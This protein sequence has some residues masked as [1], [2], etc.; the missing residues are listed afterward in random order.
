[1]TAAGEFRIR[2]LGGVQVQVAGRRVDPL[3]TR[4]VDLL[5]LLASRAG[6]IQPR[7]QVA[8]RLWP[9]STQ[10]QAR[11]NLRRELHH[12][13]ALLGETAGL[14]SGPEGLGWGTAGEVEIDVVTLMRAQAAAL[15]AIRVDDPE[16]LRTAMEVVTCAEAEFLPGC[17][18]EWADEVR[19]RLR[20]ATVEVC[21]SATRYWLDRGRPDA[22]LSGARLRTRL[23]PLEEVGYHCLMLVHRDGGD[24]AGALSTYHR[25][26]GVLERE[27]GVQPGP[28]LQRLVD[29]LLD[30]Q[31]LT[32]LAQ[33][34]Q[35]APAAPTGRGTPRRDRTHPKDVSPRPEQAAFVGRSRELER[36]LAAWDGVA[37]S[38]QRLA[39]IVG[40]PGVGK[41]RLM[42][43]LGV[44]VRNRGGV[45]SKARCYAATAGLPLAPVSEWL[46]T[47]HLRHAV[48]RL[49]P[50]WRTEV[51]RLAP[52]TRATE[53][54]VP[55]PEAVSTPS[56][57]PS[58]SDAWQRIRFFESLARAVAAVGR[59]VLLCLDDVQWCD[60]ATL[61]WVAFL[62]GTQLPVPVLVV[63]TARRGAHTPAPYGDP[64]AR[65]QATA[66]TEVLNLDELDLEDMS[67]LAETVLGRPVTGEERALLRDATAGNPLSVIVA[68]RD[69]ASAS[70][71]I[72]A[73]GVHTA[74]RRR[75]EDLPQEELDLAQLLAAI[76]RDTGLDLLAEVSGRFD[77]EVAR[78]VDRLCRGRLLVRSGSRYD[79]AH[80]LVRE[81][82][83]GT[84]GPS[85]RLVAHRRVAEAL[86]RTREPDDGAQAAA[87][88]EQY[89]SAGLPRRAIPL[90]E[91]AAREAM[92]FFALD[93]AIRLDERALQLLAEQP[94][95]RS[96]DEHELAIVCSLLP[97]LTERRG[98]A[99]TSLES[100]AR[101]AAE[102]AERLG[103]VADQT[104]ALVTLFSIAFV[105]GR[106]REAE[107]MGRRALELTTAAPHLRAQGHLALAGPLLA[108]GDSVAADG[109]FERA[110]ALARPEDRLT[111]GTSTAIHAR[112]WWAHAR[113]LC[114]APDDARDLA[115]R[116]V[117]EA[118][119]LG[120]P[121][122]LTVALSYQAVTLQLLDDR[123]ALT[124]VLGEL[125]PLCARYQF[126]YYDGWAMVLRGWLDGGAEG[127]ATSRAGIDHFLAARSLTRL[128]YWLWLHADTCRRAGDTAAAAAA[129]D[130]AAVHALA[131][132]DLWWLPQVRQARA[133]LQVPA[134]RGRPER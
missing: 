120:H 70:S 92:G 16:G 109:H 78:L 97:P 125:E 110:S 85:Q 28:S 26:V 73:E 127:R 131:N 8:A 38:G 113:Y 13:R 115:A 77:D 34:V 23:E 102:L 84:L 1:M 112:A 7:A 63:G 51:E 55:P 57:V 68:A 79:F 61:S 45:V 43:E 10:T 93:D 114:G 100:A 67:R 80:D 128:P 41:T 46:R 24:V 124:D 69:A 76:G 47:P 40:E 32:A 31:A 103:Q 117:H 37:R 95:S 98:Y 99:S 107:A 11:T 96:R 18:D 33:P 42:E 122:S 17:R 118:R 83:Y 53:S 4:A 62:L 108:L 81:A 74:L 9:D 56:R 12:L 14:T 126:A 20:R 123:P 87:L 101:R 82:A 64:I 36:L 29:E 105:Q 88:A 27:L 75:F 89:A 3:P 59:P 111:N 35:L 104:A 94:P 25:C 129:L 6:E 5:A 2:V 58:S 90:L 116:A 48:R 72:R 119:L 50:T 106:I 86:E 19:E 65:L 21:D 132:D 30:N 91:A 15:E 22:A 130:S 66:H 133:D 121:W 52:V 49:D 54:P 60:R 134:G 71:A 44:A 39:L